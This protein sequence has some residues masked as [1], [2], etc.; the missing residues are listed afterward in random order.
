MAIA[1]QKKG[2][3]NRKGSRR[4][5][6]PF[7]KHINIPQEA[8]IEKLVRIN[9]PSWEPEHLRHVIR[10]IRF[11][12]SPEQVIP[13]VR[14]G[15]LLLIPFVGLVKFHFDGTGGVALDPESSYTPEIRELVKALHLVLGDKFR[16]GRPGKVKE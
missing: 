9:F 1:S 13:G 8:Y 5:R 10:D 3:R 7:G 14:D 2:N 12:A 16:V 15:A 11:P 6:E 4:E